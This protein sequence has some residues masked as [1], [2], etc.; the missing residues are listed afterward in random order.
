MAK[1][2]GLCLGISE[3]EARLKDYIEKT[4]RDPS[5]LLSYLQEAQEIFGYLPEE[6]QVIISK[7]TGIPLADIYGVVTFYSQFSLVPKGRNSI[8]VCLGTACYVKG[9]GDILA[10]IKELL[11]I[12]VG[13]VTE[14]G[15]FS[16]D[17]TRCVGACGLAPVVLINKDVYPK[18]TVDAVEEVLKKYRNK[19]E[20]GE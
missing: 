17:A 11:N 16:L 3:Q 9:A 2:N 18:M 7:E 10:R 8:S 12:E 6:V 1:T 5:L 20:P 13:G 15:L 19:E 4:G 14:D